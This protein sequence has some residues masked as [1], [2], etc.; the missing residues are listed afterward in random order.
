MPRS[1]IDPP[2][3]VFDDKAAQGSE[4]YYPMAEIAYQFVEGRNL[5]QE[6]VGSLPT[7]MRQLH[8]YYKKLAKNG[9]MG[10]WVGVKEEHYFQEYEMWI[11]FAE[12]FQLY[13]IRAIDKSLI[14]CYCL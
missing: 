9:K 5:V 10:F 4:T 8:S 6:A 3:K 12:L 13:Q 2:L 14:S 11:A 1:T 7:H